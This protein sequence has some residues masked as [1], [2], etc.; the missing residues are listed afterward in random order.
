MVRLHLAAA[1]RPTPNTF[2]LHGR[3]LRDSR[4]SRTRG[5]GCRIT[6]FPRADRRAAVARRWTVRH[7]RTE[8]LALRAPSTRRGVD[9]TMRAETPPARPSVDTSHTC[10]ETIRSGPDSAPFGFPPSHVLQLC[11][12][13]HR[14]A[15]RGISQTPRYSCRLTPRYSCRALPTTAP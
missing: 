5:S 3:T 11:V 1:R 10:N 7:D 13:L 2:P 4:R 14:R 8:P 12:S 9:T 6:E 15:P